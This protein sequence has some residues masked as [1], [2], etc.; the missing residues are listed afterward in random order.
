MS[1]KE[2]FVIIWLILILNTFLAMYGSSRIKKL[3]M[4]FDSKAKKEMGM[5]QIYYDESPKVSFHFLVYIFKS[6]WKRYPR[7]TWI[8][9]YLQRFFTI[10][11]FIL[12]L[13][14]MFMI[15]GLRVQ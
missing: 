3:I 9:F 11:Q 13:V 12:M 15:F 8:R 14:L 4:E 2:I 1:I 7:N 5:H 6:D 10:T